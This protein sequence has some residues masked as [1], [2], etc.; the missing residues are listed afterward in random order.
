VVSAFESVDEGTLRVLD[1]GHTVEHMSTAIDLTRAAGVHIRPTWLPFMPW[2]TPGDVADIIEFIDRHHLAGATDP[3]QMSIK[4]LMPRGS[5]L[6]E[7]PEVAPYL[8]GYDREALTWRWEFAHP[9]TEVLHK[10][11][12][13]IAASASDCGQ[14]T[15][16]TLDQMRAAVARTTGRTMPPIATASATP[17][18]TESWF[19][20]A[21]PTGAQALTIARS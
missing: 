9:E 20:C 3:V 2:T 12:D 1:K 14:E 19:C 8:R 11:L 16:A 6:E 10:E 21:E 4:L 5:L 18:L 17:R 13:A 15:V 7:R